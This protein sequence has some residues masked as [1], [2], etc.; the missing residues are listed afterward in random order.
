MASVNLFQRCTT[1][2]NNNHPPYTNPLDQLGVLGDWISD[3]G[4]I[5]KMW[6]YTG[7]SNNMMSKTKKGGQDDDDY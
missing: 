2:S 7:K 5:V 6:R 4:A 3:L 1:V